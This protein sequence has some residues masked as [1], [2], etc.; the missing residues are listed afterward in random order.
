MRKIFSKVPN[1]KSP[2]LL[3]QNNIFKQAVLMQGFLY[4]WHSA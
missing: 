1:L 2:Q 4:S 3:Q